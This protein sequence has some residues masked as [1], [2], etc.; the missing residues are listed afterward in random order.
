MKK[1]YYSFI[2]VFLTLMLACGQTEIPV[3]SAADSESVLI[4]A[5]ASDS[6]DTD[7]YKQRSENEVLSSMT[8]V[9]KNENYIFFYSENEDLFALKDRKNGT[10]WWSSP[11]NAMGDPIAKGMIK[12]ELCSSLVLVYGENAGR[13]TGTFRSSKNGKMSFE[14]KNDAL[15][16]TYRFNAGGFIVP[17][18]YKLEKDGLSAKIITSEIQE[19]QKDS[20]GKLILEIRI[21]PNLLNASENENGY[22]IVP[23]G[24]GAAIRFNNGKTYARPYSGNVYGTDITAVSLYKPS[25][26]EK[27]TMPVY[28]AVRDDGKSMLAVIESGDTNSVIEAAV[29]RQS[30]SSYN[31]CSSKFVLRSEDIY[32]MNKEPLTVFEKEKSS[33]SELKVRFLPLSGK[34]TDYTDAAEKYREY[35]I[36]ENKIQKKKCSYSLYVNFY[37]GTEKKESVLGIPVTVKKAVTTFDEA[38]SIS[39]KLVESGAKN[40]VVSYNDWT[41]SE[42]ENKIETG[43]SPSS[44]LGSGKKFRSMKEYFK[45]NNILFY[46]VS[47]NVEFRSGNG[48]M[49]YSDTA[50]RASGQL[51]R[52]KKYNL[53]YSTEDKSSDPVS[54]ISP[55]EFPEIFRKLSKSYKKAGLSGFCPGSLSNQLF[56]D[57]GKNYASRDDMALYVYE[58]IK[59]CRDS[60]GSV[61]MSNP[62]AYLADLA[63]HITEM[64]VSS[65]RY[66]IFDED[67]PF[68]QMV[69]HGLVPYSVES[70]NS[71]SDPDRSFLMAAATGSCLSFDLIS[72]EISE[73][74]DTKYDKLFYADASYWTE[75]AAAEYKALS[76]LLEP[77]KDETII[78]YRRT[79]NVIETGYSGGTKI[80]VD[81][82]K[83]EITS[84]TQKVSLKEIK[85]TGGKT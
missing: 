60:T 71:C 20:E 42:I 54:L 29:S 11:I 52:Q 28:A 79:G 27:I 24:C 66:D 73:L 38:K 85:K 70:V 55:S 56:A 76:K 32:Y 35:L 69:L 67:I 37:G 74:K 80:K 44:K 12:N 8:E 5:N 13:T 4:E 25:V 26:T 19:K 30:K 59:K 51:S 41:D 43:A 39:K 53:A 40:I 58:G 33:V 2:S 47:N 45:K 10:V 63:D 57:Y 78:S 65:S 34:N 17:V 82:D 31:Y 22:Y 3:F 16:V 49:E 18:E 62:N 23:D 75:T 9:C 50:V 1:K 15:R 7:D 14:K 21:L 36:S 83:K 61:L 64:P 68:C 6:E 81:L 72:E 46:P 84:P 77:V 48:Y